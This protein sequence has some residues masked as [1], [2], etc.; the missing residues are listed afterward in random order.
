MEEDNDLTGTL[1]G[2]DVDGEVAFYQLEAGS[3]NA[4]VLITDPETGAYSYAPH[5]DFNGPDSFSFSVTDADGAKSEAGTVSITVTPVNDAPVFTENTP[6]E[7]MSIPRHGEDLSFTVEATDVDGDDL[8]YTV[9]N[10]PLGATFNE[11]TAT[12]NWPAAFQTVGNNMVVLQASDGEL[13]ALRALAIEVYWVF[14]DEDEDG[15][16]D[17][18]ELDYGLDPTTKDTDED[19]I[20]DGTEFGEGEEPADTDGDEIIDALDSDSDDDGISD[21]VEAGDDDLETPPA[22]TDED[23]V[24]DWQDEDSDDDEVSDANDNCVLLP[25]GEQADIDNDGLGDVC[26]SD[27]DGDGLSNELEEESGSDPFDRDSD[28]DGIDDSE[29]WGCEEE[30]AGSDAGTCAP[31][32][33]DNDGVIDAVDDDS[34]NDGVPDVEE[35]WRSG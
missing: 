5:Q 13:S 12:F 10:M 32:D 23:G 7:N 35:N 26:D 19:G 22:D 14:I 28:N 29:E 11:E 4:D 21:S 16:D 15:I 20:D 8:T 34:D 3:S 24:G 30:A 33:S 18:L 6:S 9:S 1:A 27:A 17:Y 25:N 2:A 31:A